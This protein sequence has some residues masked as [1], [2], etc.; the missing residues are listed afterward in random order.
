MYEVAAISDLYKVGVTEDGEDAISE[1]Y[2]VQLEASDGRRWIHAVSYDGSEVKYHEEGFAYFPDNR[3]EASAKAEKLAATVRSHL[4]AG[5]AIDFA[6]WRED[7]PRYGSDAYQ[8]LDVTGY[9]K[10]QERKAEEFR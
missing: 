10:D 8:E 1:R 6:H 5:G 3:E 4:E 9:F 7:R 2:F